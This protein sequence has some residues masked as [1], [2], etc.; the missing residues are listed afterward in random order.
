TV[1]RDRRSEL[2]REPVVAVL[3]T[4]HARAGHAKLLGEPHALVAA[5]TAAC[6]ERRARRAGLRDGV[7][8]VTVR[9]DR[10]LRDTAQRRLPV[11]AGRVLVRDAGVTLAAGLR[12]VEL[13]DG[14]AGVGC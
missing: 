11:D 10:R 12:N 2:A 4:L 5:R 14:R 8:A 1:G 6:A 9:T 13:K 7:D 3:V